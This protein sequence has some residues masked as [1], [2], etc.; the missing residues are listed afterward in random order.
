MI[1]S[2]CATCG[3]L[4]RSEQCMRCL[5]GYALAVD[6]SL[7]AAGLPAED[8]AALLTRDGTRESGA[9]EIE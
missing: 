6:D 3:A 4:L 8:A 1:T 2:T 7:L 9:D 5:L